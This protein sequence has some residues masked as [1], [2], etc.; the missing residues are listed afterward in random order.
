MNR[1]HHRDCCP[2]CSGRRQDWGF[3]G[4]TTGG[5]PTALRASC[6]SMDCSR[7]QYKRERRCTTPRSARPSRDRESVGWTSRGRSTS[8]PAERSGHTRHSRR[9][10]QRIPVPI[11]MKHRPGPRSWHPKG[12]QLSVRTTGGR[13]SALP[14]ASIDRPDERRTLQRKRSTKRTK[15]PPGCR[16]RHYAAR[17]AGQTIGARPSAPPTAMNDPR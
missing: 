1:R 13:S 10:R 15:L 14:T 17:R 6:C 16:T 2:Q 9:R 11:R 7:R 12:A 4:L 8:P 3:V 5:R